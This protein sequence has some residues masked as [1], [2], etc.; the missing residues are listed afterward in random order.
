M[1][2]QVPAEPGTPPGSP[3]QT[4]KKGVPADREMVQEIHDAPPVEEHVGDVR[5]PQGYAWEKDTAVPRTFTPR[6][7]NTPL[8]SSMEQLKQHIALVEEEKKL[9][10]SV[11]SAFSSFIV[12]ACS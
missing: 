4:V 7:L 3:P 10:R 5:G 9:V 11:V 6:D 2:S 8:Q 12:C 1:R